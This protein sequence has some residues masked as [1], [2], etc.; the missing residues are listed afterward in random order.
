MGMQI[1][2]RVYTEISAQGVVCA[3]A[4]GLGGGISGFERAEG[5]QGGG[6]PSDGRSRAHALE[7]AAEIFGVQRDRVHQG[8]EC[9]PHRAGAC[10]AGGTPALLSTR[11]YQFVS[12]ADT[13]PS[14]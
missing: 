12:L 5:M 10:W 4:A 1:S 9:D 6:R 2:C 11:A 8:Q 3:V 14:A 7:R 13:S